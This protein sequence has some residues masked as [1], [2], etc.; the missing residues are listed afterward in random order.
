MFA[1]QL[2][3][4]ANSFQ[5]VQLAIKLDKTVVQL[6]LKSCQDQINMVQRQLEVAQ[7]EQDQPFITSMQRF[8][9]AGQQKM[10]AVQKGFDQFIADF[11]SVA[12]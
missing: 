7:K 11:P 10:D 2:V 5:N 9:W 12:K 6:T 8:L 4:L 3:N 1:V